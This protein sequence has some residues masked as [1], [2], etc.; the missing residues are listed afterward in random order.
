MS[1]PFRTAAVSSIVIPATV[2]SLE[3]GWCT[4][5]LDIVSSITFAPGST[6]RKL[7]DN[8]FS[9]FES[10]GSLTIPTSVEVIGSDCFY[11]CEQL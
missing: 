4:G 7:G 2:E 1:P 6:L 5:N 9:G 8:A 11:G 10:I 3:K